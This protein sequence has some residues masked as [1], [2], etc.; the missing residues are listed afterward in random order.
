MVQ[1]LMTGNCELYLFSKTHPETGRHRADSLA[2]DPDVPR[3]SR[4]N[5]ATQFR[6]PGL[7]QGAAS[8]QTLSSPTSLNTV[9]WQLHVLIQ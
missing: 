3:H 5:T 1:E 2:S 7:T 8:V 4:A 9:L 6:E